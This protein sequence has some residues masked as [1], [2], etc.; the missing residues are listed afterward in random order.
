MGLARVLLVGLAAAAVDAATLLAP[1]RLLGA[2]TGAPARLAPAVAPVL[3]GL[4]A[5][6]LSST[7]V[8]AF[9][10]GLVA[11]LTTVLAPML[12]YQAWRMP[13]TVPALLALLPITVQLPLAML[14]SIG[15]Y[16]LLRYRRR[17]EPLD[18]EELPP[19]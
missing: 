7:G 17:E 14:S 10:S 11:S 3:A 6:L 8:Q 15:S 16:L 9:A 5:G 12:V 18:L 4:V 13:A 2:P 1:H 19:P